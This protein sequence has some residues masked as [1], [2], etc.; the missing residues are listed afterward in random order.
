M[1][2][3]VFYAVRFSPAPELGEWL[4]VAVV[5]EGITDH[6]AGVI[7]SQS[8]DRI[9]AAFGPEAVERVTSIGKDLTDLIQAMVSA[10]DRGEET[11]PI[12]TA[13]RDMALSLSFSEQIV[14][15]E[16]T[17]EDALASI[18]EKYLSEES[19]EGSAQQTEAKTADTGQD[20]EIGRIA[21]NIQ[22]RL[23]R[24]S[25]EI[26][27]ATVFKSIEQGQKAIES[28]VHAPEVSTVLVVG[29]GGHLGS[30][31]LPK[32]LESGKRVRLFDP[33][34][35]GTTVVEI[36]HPN[37]TDRIR[38]LASKLGYR[39]DDLGLTKVHS[40]SLESSMD[41]VD[42][43]IYIPESNSP[44]KINADSIGIAQA[45]KAS[46]A[47]KFVFADKCGV[48]G[49]GDIDL[50]KALHDL[51]NDQ[52]AMTILRLGELYGYSHATQWFGDLHDASGQ[53]QIHPSVNVL[54]AQAILNGKVAA[55]DSGPRPFL[56]VEDAV[57][58]IA[59][60]LE[61]PVGV[62]KGQIY[63]VG[64]E[65]Q[66]HTVSE[67][68]D[69]IKEHAST[70]EFVITVAQADE[71]AG[72]ILFG[73]MSKELGFS[74]SR[75]MEEGIARLIIAL[76][77]GTVAKYLADRTTEAA[78]HAGA[79]PVE[80]SDIKWDNLSAQPAESQE[81]TADQKLKQH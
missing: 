26:F 4:N 5:G 23:T 43:V 32:L 68:A 53:T 27:P 36:F 29:G 51:G 72:Q 75:T 45:A 65:D 81:S 62:V 71:Q 77:D 58:A 33:S 60:V 57:D 37:V 67:V 55:V 52:F 59:A 10:H 69:L 54:T 49:R 28:I 20:N 14:V 80:T 24:F 3:S 50:E 48:S 76:R 64:S 42:V 2:L 79:E 61:A 38:D 70:A 16:G 78:A 21:A 7:L 11:Q 1:S 8:M 73:K 12:P 6:K 19:Q 40:E 66:V 31:L 13:M 44:D 9:G 15:F 34:V 39:A 18:A 30:A 46:G 35:S 63:N 47:K 25:R 41:G 22:N 56:H 74:T 17:F